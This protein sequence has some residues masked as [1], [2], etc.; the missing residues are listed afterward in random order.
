MEPTPQYHVIDGRIQTWSLE[1]H[2]V[3]HCNLRCEHCCT[4]SPHLPQRFTDPEEMERDLRRIRGAVLP[5]V[6][7]LTGG[8]P[9]L[10]PDLVGLLEVARAADVAP[11]IQLTTNGLL[12]PGA[13][14]RL[15]QLIDRLTVSW[16]SSRPLPDA[17]LA[18]IEAR[19]EAAGVTLAVK[20]TG[21]FSAMDVCPPGQ[22]PQSAQRVHDA[23]W[24]KVRC[25]LLHRGR[26]YQCT[27]PPHLE[28]WLKGQG[29]ALA[30]AERDGVALEGPHLTRRI[31]A[32][33]QR[34]EPLGACSFCLG[35]L[36]PLSPH[37]QLP[38]RRGSSE[39]APA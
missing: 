31:L 16:Y 8:E 5:A 18:L 35:A 4:L 39:R 23:C 27:R 32:Y 24:L 6:L 12:L 19:C 7:K 10:H 11:Q 3:D 20:A 36:G 26:F 17:T 34:P 9:L 14:P 15:W 2:P 30:L 13:P 25:H 37:R 21:H 38:R 22:D 33:L 29:V 28:D 1:I